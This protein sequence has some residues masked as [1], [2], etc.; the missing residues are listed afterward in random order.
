MDVREAWRKSGPSQT[1]SRPAVASLTCS[2]R[3]ARGSSSTTRVEALLPAFPVLYPEVLYPGGYI[4]YVLSTHPLEHPVT[5]EL[6][7]VSRRRTPGWNNATSRQT[8]RVR[9][10]GRPVTAGRPV[11]CPPEER[12]DRRC[13]IAPTARRLAGEGAPLGRSPDARSD[14]VQGA[15]AAGQPR[16]DRTAL[17]RGRV[18]SLSDLASEPALGLRREVSVRPHR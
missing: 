12:G 5:R 11:A 16:A 13:V 4:G 10:A 14:A 17:R 3:Q 18:P 9:V 15:A 2:S 1:P 6:L 7:D 8:A